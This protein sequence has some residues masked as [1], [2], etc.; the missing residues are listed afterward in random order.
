MV[1]RK[2]RL[3]WVQIGPRSNVWHG[4]SD[5]RHTVKPSNPR[6]I[7]LTIARLSGMIKPSAKQS[8]GLTTNFGV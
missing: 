8:D 2:V 4:I 1:A 7:N 3:T 6:A 5:E